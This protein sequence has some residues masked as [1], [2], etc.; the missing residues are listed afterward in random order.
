[1]PCSSSIVVRR[2]ESHE[3][4]CPYQCPESFLGEA[5]DSCSS[6]AAPAVEDSWSDPSM[7]GVSSNVLGAPGEPTR[8][9][10]ESQPSV[11]DFLGTGRVRS[12]R[13]VPHPAS[14][15]CHRTPHRTVGRSIAAPLSASAP[16]TLIDNSVPCAAPSVSSE[17]ML[18]QS[19]NSPSLP[20]KI[21]ESYLLAIRTSKSAG[22]ACNPWG[23]RTVTVRVSG[24]LFISQKQIDCRRLLEAIVGCRRVS[25][26]A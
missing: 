5:R 8:W 10:I 1:M 25:C 14:G 7:F 12:R 11:A 26:S 18:L 4:H 17:S 15:S 19:T 22:R 23:L 16:S 13:P 2:I 24:D 21:V 3:T 20:I 9:L 6:A